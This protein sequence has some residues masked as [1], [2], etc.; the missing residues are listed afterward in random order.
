M[1]VTMKK[2]IRHMV[3]SPKKT[4]RLRG[5]LFLPPYLLLCITLSSPLKASF[6]IRGLLSPC[7][8]HHHRH[9]PSSH[10]GHWEEKRMILREGVVSSSSSPQMQQ[11]RCVP[12]LPQSTEDET[13]LSVISKA[14]CLL[15][16]NGNSDINARQGS[17]KWC[18]FRE[19]PSLYGHRPSPSLKWQ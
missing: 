8:H 5:F 18:S 6:S 19:S 9:I 13:P 16:R 1:N 15:L 10:C 7:Y 12:D 14:L 4:H 2:Q 17:S 11:R 3:A